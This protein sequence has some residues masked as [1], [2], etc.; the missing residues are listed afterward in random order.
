MNLE[1]KTYWEKRLAIA[2]KVMIK[3]LKLQI[4]GDLGFLTNDIRKLLS[5]GENSLNVLNEKEIQKMNK[6]PEKMNMVSDFIPTPTNL[7]VSD[8][9]DAVN[10]LYVAENKAR[11]ELKGAQKGIR[12]LRRKLDKEKKRHTWKYLY[13]YREGTFT[14]HKSCLPNLGETVIAKTDSG[15]VFRVEFTGTDEQG[16]D[17]MLYLPEGSF[18]FFREETIIAWMRVPRE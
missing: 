4:K 18:S 12:R 8:L 5:E 7:A 17:W 3:A 1:P 2:E 9:I 10:G 11:N 6:V 13:S 15:L 14:F 16:T